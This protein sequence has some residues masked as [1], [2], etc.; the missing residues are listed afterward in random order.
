MEWTC[1]CGSVVAELPDGGT[2]IVCYCQS[3]RSFVERLGKAE[4]L[5]AAGG[6]DL[7]QVAPDGVRFVKGREHLAWMRITEKGP[8]RWYATCCNTPLANTLGTPGVPFASFQAAF[9]T[10][11]AALGPVRARVH[12]KDATARVP[13]PRGSLLPLLA[14]FFW[15]IAAARL[16]GRWKTN[17]FFGPDGKPVAARREPS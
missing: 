14:G 11:Q 16:S 8:L 4:R 15:R 13:E 3:C 7:L 2:R 5:D 9:A 6:S 12:L 10:P 17:P 1:E